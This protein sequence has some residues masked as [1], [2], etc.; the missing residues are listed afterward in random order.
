M[1]VEDGRVLGRFL[2]AGSHLREASISPKAC[3]YLGYSRLGFGE[4]VRG[5]RGCGLGSAVIIICKDPT[6]SPPNRPLNVRQL[7]LR[8]VILNRIT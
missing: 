4:P 5:W 7:G 6:R 2:D 1:H 8:L 3:P